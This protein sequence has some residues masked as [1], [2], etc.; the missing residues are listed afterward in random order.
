MGN[1][2][3]YDKIHIIQL[4][5]SLLYN[6]MVRIMSLNLYTAW[7]AFLLGCIAGA[8]PGIFFHNANWLGGYSSWKRRM[9]RLAHISFFGIG[10]LNL[11]FDLTVYMLEIQSGLVPISYLLIIGAITMPTICYLS[12]WN[13]FF[14]HLFFI[15]A[16]SVVLGITLFVWRILFI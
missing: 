12:A 8:I 9:I 5:Y 13:M 6:N 15:P 14:R 7:I 16:I 4:I 2:T 10:A 3:Q 1:L 11:A